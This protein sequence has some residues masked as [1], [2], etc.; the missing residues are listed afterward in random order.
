MK[1]L[2][3]YKVVGKDNREVLCLSVKNLLAHIRELD[4]LAMRDDKQVLGTLMGELAQSVGELELPEPITSSKPHMEVAES[5]P[6]QRQV[7]RRSVGEPEI[8][9]EDIP[10]PVKKKPAY[11]IRANDDE[12]EEA[13]GD[14]EAEVEEGSDEEFKLR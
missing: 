2:N 5:K 8:D 4:I 14:D 11:D 3:L 7:Q 12:G 1:Q 13:E 10:R 9:E 6:V